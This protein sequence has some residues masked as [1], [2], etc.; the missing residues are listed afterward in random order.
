MDD[1]A[2]IEGLY[3]DVLSETKAQDLT[4]RMSRVL[5]PQWESIGDY[6]GAK[7]SRDQFGAQL[8]GFGKLIPD[9]K[10]QMEEHISAGNRHIVRGRASGT[11]VG[12]LFGVA[13]SGKKFEIMSVD[14]HTVESG[15]ITRT[16]HVEDWAS[17]LRQ[18]R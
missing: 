12:E 15:K 18:L 16:Y 13:P 5:A 9:L 6:T 1:K 14:I 7:K 8:A 2:L 4:E 3:R 10:W 11:P 17:A